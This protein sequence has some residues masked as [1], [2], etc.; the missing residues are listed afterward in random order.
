MPARLLRGRSRVVAAAI[1]ALAA[2]AVVAVVLLTRGGDAPPPALA[3]AVPYDG[4]SPREPA[5]TGTRVIVAL[6]RPALGETTLATPAAQQRYVRSLE[7]ESASLRSALGARGVRLSGVV[8]YTRT[9]NGFAA[10]VRTRDLADLSSLGV[11]AQPVRRFYPAGSEPARVPGLRAPRAAAPLGGASVA[12]LDSGVDARHPLLAGR[13]DPGYDAVDGDDD[14]AP[15]RDPR[16]GRRETGGTALAG[17]LVAAGERVLPIRVAGLQPATTGAGLEE[18]AISDQLLAGLERAVDPDA[19][20]ATDDHVPIAL[21][22]VNSPYAGFTRSPEARAV[23]T[24]AALGTLVVAPAGN[25]GAAAGPEGMVG[26][27][28]AAPAALTA[29][30]LAA[31]RAV[32]RIDVRVGGA[33]APG[34]ALLAGA[35]PPARLTTAGPLDTADPA[36][37]LGRGARSLRGK[38][39]VVRAGDAPVARAAAAAA[40]GARAVLVADPRRRPLSALPAGRVAVPVIGVTGAA[41]AA[42]LEQD[43]G[44]TAELGTPQA[45]RAPSAAPRPAAEAAAAPALSPFTSRGPAAGGAVKPDVAAAGAALTAIPGSGAAI[46]GGSAVAAAHAAIG[47]A[48]LVRARPSASPRQLRVALTQGADPRL[49]ARGAGAGLVRVPAREAA[50]VARTRPAGSGD[51]CPR[52]TGCV[53]IELSNQGAAPARLALALDPDPGTEARLGA[54]GVRIPPGGAREAEIDIGA[55]AAGVASGRLVARDQAGA[56]VVS[57]PFALP[58]EP[59]AP[60]PAGPLALERRRGRVTGVHF[61][62]GA[63]ERGD[64]LRGGSALSLTERLDLALVRA[65][66]NRLVRRLT[67][68]GGARELLPAEY[69]YA[70]PGATLRGLGRGRYAFRVRARSPQEGGKPT[71]A[72]SAAFRR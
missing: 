64:P 3:D 34:A 7:R 53:R 60:V 21:V 52:R 44:A 58:T 1:V 9:F 69:A 13:L 35:A 46:V 67:P 36:E 71:V 11:R 45:G 38:L 51:P 14:P 25:E 57:Q 16:D 62:L 18:V 48:Q 47:A 4:R 8:T 20:G 70:L 68:P 56:T 37:L 31:P 65:R 10:T 12:V 72:R 61:P 27:P 23:Q 66:G 28:G 17:I 40:A 5:G 42:V 33:D 39:A 29:G 55:G 15:G 59:P 32:A 50:I 63:F 41:A 22:G 54:P 6:P 24:A 19:D 49:P 26:S 2:V 43:A 30:A